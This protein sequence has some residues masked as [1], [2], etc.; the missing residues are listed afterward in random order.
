[1]G[2]QINQAMSLEKALVEI[3][4]G[5]GWRLGGRGR[6]KGDVGGEAMDIKC[7][8]TNIVLRAT[9]IVHCGKVPVTNPDDLNFILGKPQGRRRELVPTKLSS[10]PD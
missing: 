3:R 4:A 10:D 2:P 8:R 6:P 7:P 5:A 9:G 1:M